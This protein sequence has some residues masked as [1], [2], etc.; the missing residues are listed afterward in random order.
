M[1]VD[2]SEAENGHVMR[3][4]RPTTFSMGTKPWKLVDVVASPGMVAVV[5]DHPQRP[6]R[7][8]TS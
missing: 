5:A 6:L 2:R 4:A 1:E 8:V 7:H 3:N